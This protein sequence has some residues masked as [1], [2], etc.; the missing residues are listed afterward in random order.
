MKR[1]SYRLVLADDHTLFRQGIRKLIEEIPGLDVVGEASDGIEL[2]RLVRRLKPDMVVLDISMP[3]LGGIEA[4]HEILRLTPNASV[5]IITMHRRIEYVHHAFAAGAMG[6]LLK[7]DTGDE[8]AEAVRSIQTGKRYVTRRLASDIADDLSK[9]YKHNGT[10]PVDPLTRRERSILKLI[11]EGNTS[12]MIADIL[13]ISPRT[14]QNHRFHIMQKLNIKSTV[15]L[16]KYAIEK[17]YVS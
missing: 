8:F 6:F 17:G 4:T 2:M 13:Y 10:L 5:L 7:E 9:F 14:V 3:K 12:R 1:T 15:D 11:A 16:V